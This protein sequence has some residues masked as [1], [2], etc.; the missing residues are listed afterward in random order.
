MKFTVARPFKFKT[1][2]D[3]EDAITA[4]FDSTEDDELTITGLVLTIGTSRQVLAD[5]EKRTGYQEIVRRSKC[6]IEHSYELAL[7][8]RGRAGEIFALKNFGWK[9]S[10]PYDA[11]SETPAPTSIEISV[12]DGRKVG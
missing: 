9:D 6:L 1:P 12:I 7:R 5:Y 2:Q 3:L 8:S 11:E 4:Y 10:F